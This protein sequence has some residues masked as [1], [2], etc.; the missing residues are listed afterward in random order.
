MRTDEIV[1]RYGDRK[2]GLSLKLLPEENGRGSSVLIEGSSRALHLLAELLVAV[3]DE[4]ANDGFGMG[5]KSAGSFH[6]SSTSE[7]GVYIHRLDE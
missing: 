5:P 3:A 4:K 2:S 6:F 7:F 1:S